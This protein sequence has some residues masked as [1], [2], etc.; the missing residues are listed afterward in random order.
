MTDQ[1]LAEIVR[2]LAAGRSL[3]DIQRDCLPESWRRA[4]RVCAAAG[5]FDRALYD[6]V[7]AAH[8][9]PDAPALDELTGRGLLERAGDDRWRIRRSEAVAW[10][11]E[12]QP[13]RDRLA[14]LEADIAAWLAGRGPQI[15]RLRHLLVADPAAAIA[16]FEAEF[17]AADRNRDFARCQ[18]LI[19]VLGDPKR[20]TYA[21]PEVAAL[22]LE[23]AGYLRAR[24]F[25]SATWSRSAQYLEPDGLAGQADALLDGRG[26]RVWQVFAPTGTGKTV[27]LQWLIA[28]RCVPAE[29]DIPCARIDF[30]VVDPVVSARYPWL[31]LLDIAEQLERRW[32]RRVFERLDRFASYRGLL[33]R[34]DS[35]QARAAAEGLT[36]QDPERLER[37]VS[38]IFVRRFNDAAGA[39][40]VLLVVDT[41]EEVLLGPGADDLLRALARIVAQCPSLRLILAGRYD[42]RERAGAALAAFG[43]VRPVALGDFTPEQTGRYLREI[44]HI[45]DPDLVAAVVERTGGHPFLVAMFADLIAEEP[46]TSPADLRAYRD[47][48]LRL[49]ID[50]VIRRIPDPDVRWLVRYG[51]VPRRL[52]YADLHMMWPF[53]VSGRSG[54]TDRDDPRADRHHLAGD[55]GV[56]PVGGEVSAK[57]AV[58]RRLLDYAAQRSWVS[59]PDRDGRL[60]VFHQ[61]VRAPMRELIAAQPVALDLHAAFRQRFDDLAAAHPQAPAPFEREAYYHRVQLGDPGAQRYWDARIRARRAAGDLDGLAGL[62][63][64]VLTGDYPDGVIEPGQRADALVWLAYA[65]I[66]RARRAGAPAADPLWNEAEGFL[67]R[68]DR[69]R[70][71]AQL[72]AGGLAV[73]MYAAT[74]CVGDRST[75]AAS[76]VVAAL[77]KASADDR[78][79]LLRVL[80]DAAGH[81]S[82][83]IFAEALDL[84]GQ[85]RPDQVEPLALALARDAEKAGRF[86][87][88]LDWCRRA[89]GVRAR[90][91]EAELLISAYQPGTALEV[92]A[93]V[94][95]DA[96]AE[97]VERHRLCGRACGRLGISE[98][99]V[100]YLGSAVEAAGEVTDGRRAALLARV[101]QERALVLGDLLLL[102]E[103]EHDLKLAAA[104]WSQAGFT[105]GH[106]ESAY[107]H[108]RFLVRQVG[109][110]RAAAA[111][112]RPPVPADDRIGVLWDELVAER[113]DQ[114]RPE[115]VTGPPQ[116]VAVVIAARLARDW[117]AH[118]HLLGPL[119]EAMGRI[120]PP[121][122]RLGVLAELARHP[123]PAPAEEVARLREV[124]TWP[125]DHPDDGPAQ[126]PLLAVL[127]R[128]AGD[129]DRAAVVL[130]PVSRADPLL[131]SRML[132]AAAGRLAQPETLLPVPSYP[133]LRA[134]G[135]RRL[136]LG[137]GAAAWYAEAVR[138]CRS[139]DRP[140]RW[141]ID[142]YREAAEHL[143]DPRLRAAATDL[144]WRLGRMFG[145]PEPESLVAVAALAAHPLTWPAG[146]PQ[147]FYELQVRL[148]QDWRALT[149]E[150]GRA[151]AA[152]VPPDRLDSDDVLLHGL[153]WE[154]ATPAAPALWR[155]MPSR[156]RPADV[157]WLQYALTTLGA[158]V[159]V[160]GVLGPE[161]GAALDC[162][163]LTPPLR[164]EP[165]ARLRGSVARDR[166]AR[167]LSA[168]VVQAVAGTSHEDYGYHVADLYQR[169]GYQV[170]SV[171]GLEQV[172]ADEPAVLHVCGRLDYRD[173]GPHFRLGPGSVLEPS[174]VVRLLR[175][176]R[177]GREPVLV[178]DP[179]YPGSPYDVPWQIV[180]RNLFAAHVFAEGCVPAVLATGLIRSGGDYVLT[181]ADGLA[182]GRSPLDLVR[183]IRPAGVPDGRPL[184]FKRD[185]ELL[186]ARSTTLFAAPTALL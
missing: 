125:P 110:L 40:P 76:L 151:L 16:L 55:D 49:L 36:A 86:D 30:D 111:L 165:L 128:L 137:T 51:V 69:L 163:D 160:D 94:R 14:A 127:E 8:G 147:T 64:D 122:A 158:V 102:D 90:L 107:L 93:R 154:L 171:P 95:P 153:P 13:A 17:R 181:I 28:R 166:G 15:E 11:G 12:W 73:A 161:T 157:R 129:P 123:G 72:P 25:W 45:T 118:R 168:V 75:E 140:S 20:L 169:C 109:D 54:V 100:G 24:L 63:R 80:A 79:D 143:G 48:A 182:H 167:R 99:A 74:L 135:L 141:A 44:R 7:L 139:V 84:A 6:T 70:T 97:R 50:R 108:H 53:L 126:L 2:L 58:W 98:A 96:P 164:G 184:D 177:P 85:R 142:I 150:L 91:R 59:E 155:A 31:L 19:D 104:L 37:A 39:G 82:G 145:G 65:A 179:P 33:D 130:Q 114:D 41:M 176:G 29:F 124:L 178:L 149:L 172:L 131:G 106:P 57:E 103:A 89:G 132:D 88:A 87:R 9:A 71:A 156:A 119:A 180:L 112:Q 117:A 148:V 27:Q 5:D 26:P 174:D 83:V 66:E 68:A 18:D 113:L 62:A 185:D 81:A 77:P 46:A 10:M 4:L 61:K 42:L 92:L 43:D 173:S 32:A 186:A 23:R 22:R 136:A 34:Q 1:R 21:G 52:Y 105:E 78:I 146:V 67:A 3:E 47:P 115:P 152:P 38:E 120:S 175:S 35:Q 144:D 159:E 56:F 101:H 116:Q 60:V 138:L 134:V 162:R 133:L 121:S 170:R 183:A